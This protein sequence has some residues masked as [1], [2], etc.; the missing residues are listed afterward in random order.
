MST[1]IKDRIAAIDAFGRK[2][3]NKINARIEEEGLKG[4][5]PATLARV[6]ELIEEVKEAESEALGLGGPAPDYRDDP[7]ADDWE[8]TIMRG[9]IAVAPLVAPAR[10]LGRVGP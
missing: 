1:E 2:L 7:L 10:Y 4:Q 3:A 9:G 5:S 8:F 6:E